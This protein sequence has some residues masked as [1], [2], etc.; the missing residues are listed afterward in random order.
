MHLEGSDTF[1]LIVT[2]SIAENWVFV[3]ER[4]DYIVISKTIRW[5]ETSFV[6]YAEGIFQYFGQNIV[7]LHNN[8]HTFVL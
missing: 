3:T 7:H 1:F 8:R 4:V 2:K 5:I 6:T